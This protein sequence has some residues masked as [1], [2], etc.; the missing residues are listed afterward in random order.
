METRSALGGSV[1]V[2]SLVDIQPGAAVRG[3]RRTCSLLGTAP[4][5]GFYARNRRRRSKKALITVLTLLASLGAGCAAGERRPAELR[6]RPGTYGLWEYLEP[7]VWHAAPRM[8]L[9]VHETRD[10][11]PDARRYV[12]ISVRNETVEVT[13]TREGEGEHAVVASIEA[14]WRPFRDVVKERR[15]IDFIV[16]RMRRLEAGG[17]VAR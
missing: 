15:L 6:T 4:N 16:A 9:T 1:M 7:A 8:E 11:A 13:A 14:Q 10:H 12:L 2:N 5:P 17:G 3:E